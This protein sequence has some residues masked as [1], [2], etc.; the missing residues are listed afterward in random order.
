M[1]KNNNPD[2]LIITLIVTTDNAQANGV[3]TNAVAAVVIDSNNVL[4][5][6]Q[7]VSFT[8]TNGAVIASSAITDGLGQAR[9]ILTST[10]AGTVSV[11]A[12]I[13]S[14]EKTEMVTFT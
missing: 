8:A 2:A 13:N 12:T 10:T 6:N 14:S 1:S 4:L 11:T 7:I 3:A 5:A 9:G